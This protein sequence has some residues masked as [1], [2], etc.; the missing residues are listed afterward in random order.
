MFL[1]S[2]KYHLRCSKVQELVNYL[3]R[4]QLHEERDA[5][6]CPFRELFIFTYW[7][8]V[9]KKIEGFFNLIF[10]QLF[11]LFS[12]SSQEVIKHADVL[13]KV[14]SSAPS[15]QHSIKYKMYIFWD[16]SSEDKSIF[17]K[18]VADA[19]AKSNQLTKSYEYSLLYLRSLLPASEAARNTCITVIAFALRIPSIF[20]FDSLLKLNAI[21]ANQDHE[22]FS[23]LRVFLHNGLSEF[24]SWEALHVGALE[25][26]DRAETYGR[27]R[28]CIARMQDLAPHSC[29]GFQNIAINLPY[30][31]IAETIQVDASEVEKWVIDVIRTGLMSGKLSQTTQTL[32]ITRS[33]VC[34]F[35]LEQWQVLEQRLVS[36]KSKLRG[37]TKVVASAK[38]Q[39]DHI[40]QIEIVATATV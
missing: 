14:I 3:I 30:S 11:S 26:H 35:E 22:L 2:A 7:V 29:I 15:D 24:K 32:Y 38:R 19:Y 4:N 23:L 18:N 40:S 13:L 6:I 10:A 8:M 33:A 5:F 31:K 1:T 21:I 36:W 9:R 34:S 16:I 25:K 28:S 12:P 17:L 37:V 27:P 39:S 20:D